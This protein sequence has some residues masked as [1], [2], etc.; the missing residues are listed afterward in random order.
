[1]LYFIS[2]PKMFGQLSLYYPVYHNE[3]MPVLLLSEVGEIA[4]VLTPDGIIGVKTE[5]LTP[6][7]IKP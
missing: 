1:M 5:Y 4:E 6:C 3:H 2:L 7:R